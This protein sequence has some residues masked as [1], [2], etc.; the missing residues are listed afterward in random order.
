MEGRVSMEKS[1][2][3][4]LPASP[5]FA[6]HLAFA[7]NQRQP[8]SHL[9][10]T[11]SLSLVETANLYKETP[12]SLAVFTTQVFSFLVSYSPS[13]EMRWGRGACDFHFQRY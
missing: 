9:K 12:G 6:S 11:N 1:G 7:Q 8:R 5:I 4:S 13:E 3:D 2:S 10:L